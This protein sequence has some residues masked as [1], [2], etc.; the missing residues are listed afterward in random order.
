MFYLVQ[1]VY[2]IPIII[3]VYGQISVFFVDEGH[4]K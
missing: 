2:D 4:R 1:L 3:V